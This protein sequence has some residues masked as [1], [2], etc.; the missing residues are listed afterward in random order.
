VLTRKLK[1]VKSQTFGYYTRVNQ[2]KTFV[3]IC[4]IGLHRAFPE[5]RQVEPGTHIELTLF[6]REGKDTYQPVNTIPVFLKY[7]DHSSLLKYSLS[8]KH[9]GRIKGMMWQSLQNLL[10]AGFHIPQNGITTVFLQA[11]TLRKKS[12]VE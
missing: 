7:C 6:I 12:N 4:A 9:R 10:E 3:K 1:I 2:N 5:L 11:K 8:E